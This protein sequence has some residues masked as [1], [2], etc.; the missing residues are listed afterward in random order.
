MVAIQVREKTSS[1]VR[2]NSAPKEVSQPNSYPLS[3]EFPF[4]NIQML[5]L[6]QSL[7]AGGIGVTLQSR[8]ELLQGAGCGDSTTGRRHEGGRQ[9]TP[10]CNHPASRGG[11]GE[12]GSVI[13]VER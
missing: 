11:G 12:D 7:I 3:T 9:E 13:G 10:D 6:I 4:H 1:L 8:G 2:T 5:I